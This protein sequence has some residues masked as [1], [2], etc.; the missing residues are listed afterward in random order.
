M[1]GY[2]IFVLQRL[3]YCSGK[4]IPCTLPITITVRQYWH[5][6]CICIAC[7]QRWQTNFFKS[8]QIANPP[9][10]GLI[11]QSQI[12]KVLWPGVPVRKSQIRIFFWFTCKSQIF[13]FLHYAIFVRK[14][15]V[16]LRACGSFKSA[17]YKSAKLNIC[18]KSA[19]LTDFLSTQICGFAIRGTYLRSVHLCLR[20]TW[21]KLTVKHQDFLSLL[22]R[23]GVIHINLSRFILGFSVQS[24]FVAFCGNRGHTQTKNPWS[25]LF[26]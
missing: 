12:R 26:F 6:L 15:S 21:R 11:P 13:K 18:R 14:N 5:I 19:N 23:P 20:I 24:C 22:P 8:P 9:V 1:H 3:C 4:D 17:N 16:Y 7:M 25:S 2:I 10:L